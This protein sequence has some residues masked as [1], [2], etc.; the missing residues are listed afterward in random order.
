MVPEKV[1]KK[2]LV[3]DDEP[4]TRIFISNLLDSDG[5][6]PVLAKDKTEG[7]KKA[8]EEDPAV[9]IIDM[10]MPGESG[11]QMYRALKREE[12]LKDVPVIM[13]STI[14]KQTFFKFHIVRGS[15]S[16]KVQMELDTY[17]EKPPEAEELLGIVR[18]LAESWTS[19]GQSNG[20]NL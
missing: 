12:K 6:S 13:L 1:K 4:D 20:D 11:I 10:M 3:V 14:D 16:G 15:H 2:I 17:L 9:I 8:I 19:S 5:F 7:L 18:D